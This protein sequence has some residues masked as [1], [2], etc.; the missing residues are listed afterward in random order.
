MKIEDTYKST[1]YFW[2]DTD[3]A[4][5]RLGGSVVLYDGIP[6]Y[7]HRIESHEDGDPRG[8]I[9]PATDIGGD[10][11]GSRKKLSSPKFG[12]F[13]TLPA[14]GMVN[15]QFSDKKMP[16]AV[17]LERRS[18]AHQRHGFCGN[19]VF[20]KSPSIVNGPLATK[21]DPEAWSERV[22]SFTD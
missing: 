8:Y 4:S 13:R 18:R 1:D 20:V 7:V 3:Q 21:V 15:Y 22:Y 11:N 17:F 2:T 10:K 9:Y 16:C 5:A 6:Y 12:R 14:L 19:T